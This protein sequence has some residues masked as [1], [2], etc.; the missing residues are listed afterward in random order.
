MDEHQRLTPLIASIYDAALDPA[1]WGGAL[2]DIAA[3]VDGQTGGLLVKDS[4]N[5]SVN[6]HWHTGVDP[7][8]MQLY[9]TTYS[10]LGP[11]AKSPMGAVE[12]I[13]SVP[14]MVPYDQF[15]A[16]RFYREWARPQG[17]VDVAVAVLEK[18]PSSCAYV[19]IGRDES[20]GMVDA[21]MR[22]RLA[23]VV[24]HVR[25]AVLVGKAIEFQQAEAATFADVFDGLRAG[26]FLV[27]ATGRIIHA[28]LAGNDMLDDGD[29]LRSIGG[30]LVAGDAHVDQL[31]REAAAGAAT[32]DIEIGR[33][34]IAVPLSAHDGE[35]YVAQVLPLSA[36][37]RRRVG[38]GVAAV[39]A[40]FVRKA[41]M[42]FLTPPE[43]IGEFYDL[44]PTELRVLLGI[45]EIGGVPEVAAAMGVASTTVKTHLSRLFEKTGAGRQADLVKLVAGFSTPLMGRA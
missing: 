36:G 31:L 35:R 23:L 39:A 34:G 3:F 24:P 7:H 33:K 26:F 32:G 10:S 1:L 38:A 14:E 21:A 17:W 18:S 37:M 44:T 42:E 40:L 9:A 30:R 8:Y 22:R 25:R 13:L 19:T 16:S 20:S 43:V 27:D 29:F 6:A 5:E 2:A 12:Q 41:T 15:R 28:N 11:V 4:I 45:V